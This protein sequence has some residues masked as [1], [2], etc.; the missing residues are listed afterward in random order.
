MTRAPRA[1]ARRAVAAPMPWLPPVISIDRPANIR[2]SSPC[3]KGPLPGAV[4]NLSAAPVLHQ[5]Q[6]A[7]N[8]SPVELLRYTQVPDAGWLAPT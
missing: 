3:I 1:A 7:R 6:G 8:L 4:R 5:G 2:R